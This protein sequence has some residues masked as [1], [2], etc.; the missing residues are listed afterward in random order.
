MTLVPQ[1]LTA[2]SFEPFGEVISC[3]GRTAELI[4]AG[5][6]QKFADL[7]NIDTQAAGGRSAVHIY[8][9]QPMSLPLE[10]TVMERHPLGS[11][12]FIPLQPV[13]F[14]VIVAPPG[15]R[16]DSA[17]IRVFVTNGQQGVNLRRGTW[18]HFQVSLEQECDYLVIDRAGPGSN[19]EEQFLAP[20]GLVDK[21][22]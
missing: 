4:N 18:H 8:R 17:A 19:F 21:L 11:Q 12:A 20:P 16:V 6:T 14:L 3:E 2:G 10:I 15:K 9:S 22:A 13:P 5:H 7:I 1:A